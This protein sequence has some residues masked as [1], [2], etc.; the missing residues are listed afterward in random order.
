MGTQCADELSR[1]GC[2]DGCAW[3]LLASYR[4]LGSYSC[5][6]VAHGNQRTC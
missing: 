3:N 4:M 2:M 1:Q 5:A 6:V